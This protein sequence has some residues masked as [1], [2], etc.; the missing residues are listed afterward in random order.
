MHCPAAA[1]AAV[2]LQ[3]VGMIDHRMEHRVLR[4][5]ETIVKA[6]PSEAPTLLEPVLAKVLELVAGGNCQVGSLVG[7]LTLLARVAVQVS[8]EREGD[9]DSWCCSL[10]LR[11]GVG[12]FCGRGADATSV[13]CL[14]EASVW[15]HRRCSQDRAAVHLQSVAEACRPCYRIMYSVALALASLAVLISFAHSLNLCCLQ[16][17][18]RGRP[19]RWP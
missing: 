7:Y 16:L 8:V 12:H 18:G 19:G 2:L 10:W 4:V 11:V 5:T 3:H 17:H 13:L 14:A 9:G 1:A 6:F 15:W